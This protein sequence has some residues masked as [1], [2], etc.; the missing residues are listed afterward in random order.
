MESEELKLKK[1]DERERDG[2][3]VAECMSYREALFWICIAYS[4]TR[5]CS[6]LTLWNCRDSNCREFVLK[7]QLGPIVRLAIS[8]SNSVCPSHGNNLS[9]NGGLEIT[10]VL[11]MEIL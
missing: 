5:G 9:E 3:Y 4:L 6:T 2:G 8:V 10:L 7:G 11:F 1:M